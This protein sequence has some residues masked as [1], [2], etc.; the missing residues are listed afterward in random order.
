VIRIATRGSRQALT[1]ATSVAHQLEAVGHETELVIVD[2]LGDRSQA[3]DV[4]LHSIGGLGV[5]V[6]EVQQAVLDGRADVAVHS[7]KDLPTTTTPGLLIGA[8]TKRRS[9]ADALVGRSLVDLPSGAT[10]ATGSVRRRAQLTRARPDLRFVELRGNIPTRLEKIPDGGAVVMAVAALEVLEMTDR[11]DDVLDTAEF[12][13][14]VGQGCV[15]VDCR[16]GDARMLDAL[17]GIDDPDTRH[18]VTVERAFMAELGSG[19]SLPIGAHVDHRRLFTFLA[20]LDTGIT[21]SDT[22]ELSEGDLESDVA[23]ARRVAT[24]SLALVSDR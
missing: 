3:T 19:C 14:A 17:D 21:V 9:A 23:T 6:K 10:V 4:P 1:Q 8:F 24:E 12:V 11:I 18:D 7:A 2:T 16:D 15:A 5:F 13:P 22:I 20:D